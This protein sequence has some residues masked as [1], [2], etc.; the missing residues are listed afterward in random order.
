MKTLLPAV[1]AAHNLTASL[2]DAHRA[3][4]AD[5][6]ITEL[7]L[8]DLLRQARELGDQISGVKAAMD[9]RGWLRGF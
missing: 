7:V 2:R 9:K 8:Q 1:D 4:C 3:A 6:P 5:D